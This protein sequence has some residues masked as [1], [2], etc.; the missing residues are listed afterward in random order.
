[1]ALY[2]GQRIERIT[3]PNRDPST[4]D[5]LRELGGSVEEELPLRPVTIESIQK[6]VIP[7]LPSQK[8]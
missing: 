5:I 2:D 4:D 3:D 8:R 1:M 7:V 6:P